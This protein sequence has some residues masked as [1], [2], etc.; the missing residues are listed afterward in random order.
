MVHLPTVDCP[1]CGQTTKAGLPRGAAVTS[2]TTDRPTDD[3]DG[4]RR[5]C[6][7]MACSDGHAFYVC[8]ALAGAADQAT[9]SCAGQNTENTEVGE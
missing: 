3:V 1:V 4:Y 9:G 2:V 8:F 5:K 6:R 7:R